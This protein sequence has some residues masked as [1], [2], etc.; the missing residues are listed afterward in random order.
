VDVGTVDSYW[1]A[2]MDLLQENPP[3]DLSDRSWVIHTRTE[4][5]PPVWIA[6][7]AQVNNSMISHGCRIEAGASITQSI[8]GPGVQ[9]AA[10]SR[11]DQS[12]VLTDAIIETNTQIER[13]ILDKRI[14]I[15][16]DVQIGGDDRLVM[17]GKN[18]Q[19]PSGSRIDPGAVI[20]ADVAV[21]DF[22]SKHIKSD[23]TIS[24]IR[25]LK[26]DV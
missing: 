15:G 6:Q 24:Q 12:V 25:R 9:V 19:I 1:Q 16:Q 11:I 7:G 18:S 26:Y 14:E 8:L 17:V 5:R 3:L 22:P 20:N 10:G 2:H 13:A 21:E 23:Q 4:E